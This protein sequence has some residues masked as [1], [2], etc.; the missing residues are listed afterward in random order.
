MTS[1]QPP[2][3]PDLTAIKP[4]SE[5]PGSQPMVPVPHLPVPPE[6]PAGIDSMHGPAPRRQQKPATPSPPPQPPAPTLPLRTVR[7]LGIP[8]LLAANTCRIFT[9]RHDGLLPGSGI[10]KPSSDVASLKFH[11]TMHRPVHRTAADHSFF[12]RSV[13][14]EPVVTEVVDQPGLPAFALMRMARSLEHG[15][16]VTPAGIQRN[17][18]L[19]VLP[20][21]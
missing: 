10:Q 11:Q 8:D 13:A 18:A 2:E 6:D 12:R 7:A 5:D 21:C 19:S 20:L 14:L 9:G 3:L 4:T 1:R 16:H 15:H 17:A